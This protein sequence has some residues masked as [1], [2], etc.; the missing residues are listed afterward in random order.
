MSG[1]AE[2][3]VIIKGV[4]KKCES[5]HREDRQPHDD[6]N[7]DAIAIQKQQKK[8]LSN[9]HKQYSSILYNP[10]DIKTH[11]HTRKICTKN[12]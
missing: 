10:L 9:A 1:E 7:V 4:S 5:V 2:D 12:G 11:T 6:A 3:R 8:C